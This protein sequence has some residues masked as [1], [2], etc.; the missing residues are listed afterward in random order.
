M[1]AAET[2]LQLQGTSIIVGTSAGLGKV[3]RH[4]I[5][6]LAIAYLGYY[7]LQW[8]KTLSTYE[9]LEHFS[10]YVSHFCQNRGDSCKC[11]E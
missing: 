5:N 6:I 3:L 8:H 9:R 1:E 10:M 7:D 2:D 11:I 4:N